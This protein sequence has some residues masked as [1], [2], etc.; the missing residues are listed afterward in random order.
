MRIIPL[1]SRET[2]ALTDR[3]AALQSLLDV[4]RAE[5]E[6]LVSHGEFR[7]Y[8][9]GEVLLTP[10]DEAS[11]MV[12][13][14]SGCTTVYL[15]Q[16]GGRRHAM[17]SRTGSLT[18]VLPFSRLK[19]PMADVLVEEDSELLAIHRARFPEMIRECPV[20][21]ESLV[22]T[23]LDRAR[24]FSAINWQDEKVMS[25]GRLAA[26]LAHELNN[27]ASAA[28]SAAKHLSRAIRS[29]G[30]AAHRFGMAELST[31]QRA[32]VTGI[33]EGCQ[34][35]GRAAPPSAVDRFDMIENI[36]T[37][38]ESHD[39]ST[40]CAPD[41]VDGGVEIGTLDGLASVLP[42]AGLASAIE[43]IASAAASTSVTSDIE[44][45]TL[46][47]YDVVSAVRDFTHLDRAAV[48]EPTD[49]AQSLTETVEVLRPKAREKDAT[50]RFDVPSGLPKVTVVAA[51]LNQA[52]SNLVE[53]AMDAVPTGGEVTI[54]A[55]AQDGVVVV[56]IT[57]NGP[58]IPADIQSRIFDPFFTTKPV[59]QGAGLGLDI[60]RRVARNY[61]GDVEFTSRPGRTSFRVRL[62]VESAAPRQ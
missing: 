57:D 12:V 2:A 4:P 50:V 47:I 53:N 39:V 7:E 23:M 38:M 36:T 37:W 52:W 6:W 31:D 59:G 15:G 27:P 41:L 10:A 3:L 48:R 55:S 16:G 51:D 24:R 54:C 30:A 13:M 18:G 11:E 46:R 19:R 28:S 17:E 21:T 26:G 58:G 9:A 22:H 43:W 1:G 20:L 14:L 35:P 44:R 62:P 8:D 45:A 42:A 33:V 56:E 49:I 60:V 40:E 61:G 25:L 34:A 29:V 32:H 5:L